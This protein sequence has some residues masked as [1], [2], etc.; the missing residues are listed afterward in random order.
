MQLAFDNNY[1]VGVV[2]FMVTMLFCKNMLECMQTLIHVWEAV[3]CKDLCFCPCVNFHH[4]ELV[5]KSVLHGLCVFSV[6]QPLILLLVQKTTEKMLGHEPFWTVNMGFV[7][8]ETRAFTHSTD[9]GTSPYDS[10]EHPCKLSFSEVDAVLLVMPYTLVAASSTWTWIS[11]QQ[12][13]YFSSDPLWNEELFIDARMQLY[14]LLYSLQTFLL[15]FAL[16]CMA[17]DPADV[18]FA[19]VSSL[20]LTFLLMYFCAQSHQQHNTDKTEHMISMVLFS[21]LCTLASFFVV[22]HWSTGCV[23]KRSSAILLLL[24]VVSL[25]VMHMSTHEH[26]AAGTVILLRTVV[27]NGC[28]L[29]FIVFLAQN[30]NSWC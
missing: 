12:Q 18:E 4:A 9:N 11:L 15:F 24:T 16:L 20:V 6:F 28:S 21:L 26:T 13:G 5:R 2:V 1:V 29:F 7:Q 30:P 25:A 22:E 27:S 10:L 8:L 14:E 19:F 17:A 3:M 23:A